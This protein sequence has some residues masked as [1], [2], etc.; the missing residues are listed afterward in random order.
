[1]AWQVA[2]KEAVVKKKKKRAEKAWRRHQ[3]E[4]DITRRVWARENRSDIEA[5]LESEDP[6]E[7]G[8]NMISS[9]EEGGWEVIVTLVEH[10]EPAATS[11]SGGQDVERC[12]DVPMLRKHAASSDVVDEREAK[13]TRSPRPSEASSALS[14]LALGAVGQARQSEEWAH[15]HV[16]SGLA[17]VRDP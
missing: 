3:K 6:T 4:K 13:W 14:P 10:R 1:M 17:P 16:S 8:D 5:E 15:T 2:L 11:A 9:E 7:M 12:G